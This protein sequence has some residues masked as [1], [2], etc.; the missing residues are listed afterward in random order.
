MNSD[1]QLDPDNRELRE[2]LRAEIIAKSGELARVKARLGLAVVKYQ[3]TQITISQTQQGGSGALPPPS[4]SGGL[5]E[6]ITEISQKI[7]AVQLK[8][9]FPAN[10]AANIDVAAP[11]LQAALQEFKVADRRLVASI[12]GTIGV[13][14]P[15][16]EAYEEAAEQAAKYEGR[17]A[18][19][20]TQA[21]DG[22]RYRGRGYIGLTGRANYAMMSA[23]LGLGTRLL[24]APDDAKTPE[25]AS[26]ILVAWFVERQE[27]LGLALARDDLG[28]VRRVVNGSP[29][30]QIERFTAIYH[31]VLADL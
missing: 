3:D 29:T 12:I 25:V 16:F 20:N 8:Q 14:T 4:A 1:I 10:A 28:A 21:G 6:T 9:Y 7:T 24:D 19:G 22:V 11:Y 13:E 26:R 18:L 31:K 30:S 17:A 27:R 15:L 2:Q 5:A 23:R